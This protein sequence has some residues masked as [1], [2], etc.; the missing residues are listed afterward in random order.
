VVLVDRLRE[1]GNWLF[2]RRSVVPLAMLPLVAAALPDAW[3]FAAR[4]GPSGGL[5]VE[6]GAVAV[7]IAGQLL[8]AA[9]VAF[10]PEGTS[11]RDTRRMRAPVLNTTGAYSLVRHPL[12]LANAIVWGGVSAAL[13]VW[14]LT[15]VTVLLAWIYVERVIVAEEAFLDETFGREFR[16]WAARTPAFVPRLSAWTPPSA[17]HSW[18]R[19]AAEHNGLLAIAAVV[20]LLRWLAAQGA[21]YVP[22]IVWAGE[23]RALVALLGASIIVSVAAIVVRKA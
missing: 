17:A 1:E 11:S 19:V 21:G 12:Y 8:R 6:W 23:H 9:T 4:W 14:W 20:A 10:A 13:G 18:R 16:T 5:L 3:R 2:R 22:P 7:A 15:V